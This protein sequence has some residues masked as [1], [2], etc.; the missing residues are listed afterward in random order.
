MS[1]DRIQRYIERACFGLEDATLPSEGIDP[2]DLAALDPKRLRLYRK[3]VRHNVVSVIEMMLP[4][5]TKRLDAVR[6]GEMTRTID[7]FMHDAGPKTPH[8]RDVPSEF[9]AFAAPRWRAD[10]RLPRWIAD[11]AE[12]ELLDFTIGVAPRPGEP[13]PLVDVDAERPLVFQPP[14]ALVR[15]QFAVNGL[16]EDAEPEERPVAILVYRDADHASRFLELTPLAAAILERLIA[17]AALGEAMTSASRDLGYAMD[18]SVLSGAARLLAD[19][20]ERGV[21]LGA[22]VA[23]SK[24]A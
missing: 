2:E 14:I 9:L 24:S 6:Y 4:A 17:G 20:G 7:A 13:P 22:K 23:Q 19:L 18:E 8:L 21:L 5:T 3:L 12:L 15:L 11:H 10:A 16:A 1:T